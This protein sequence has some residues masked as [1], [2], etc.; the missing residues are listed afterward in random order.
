MRNSAGGDQ[1]EAKTRREIEIERKKKERERERE[2]D[3]VMMAI[4]KRWRR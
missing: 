4:T 2:R 1:G 3:G